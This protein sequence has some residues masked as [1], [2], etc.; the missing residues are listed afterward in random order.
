MFPMFHLV[1]IHKMTLCARCHNFASCL[2]V[3]AVVTEMETRAASERYRWWCMLVY[4]RLCLSVN[5]YA[6]AHCVIIRAS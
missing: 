1:V 2:Y 4:V 3:T 6:K 5:A